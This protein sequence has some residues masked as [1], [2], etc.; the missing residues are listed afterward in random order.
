MKANLINE[1]FTSDYVANLLKARGVANVEDYFK[2]TR[3]YL[4]PPTNLKNIRLAAALYMRVVL[5][6]KPPYSRVLIVVDSDND[7]YTSAAIIYQY[8]KRLNCHCKVDYWLH[9]GKQHGLQDHIDR[10]M[11][12]DCQYDLIILPDSSSNDAHYHDMLDT[13]GI[14]CLILDHHLTDVKLS[15]NAVVVNNQLSPNYTNK[16]LTGAGVVYQFCRMI[17]SLTGQNWADDYM[18]LAAWGIIG[19]MGSMID[20]ENRYIVET[21]LSEPYI[22]NDFFKCL[23]DKRA[24]YI[25]GKKDPSWSE[26]VEKTNAISVAFYIVPLV[27]AMIRVGTMP[28]KERLFLAFIDG[29]AMVPCGKRGAKGTMERVDIESARE[30]VNAKSKQDKLKETIT[31]RLEA[32]IFKHDLLENKVLFVR[33]EDDD[34]FPSELNGLIAMQLSARF[35]K[36]T[37]IARLNDQGFDRGSARGLNQS[38]LKDFKQFLVDSGFFEYA[39]GHA[40]AFGVSIPDQRLREFHTYANEV[41]ADIDFGE[42]AYDVNFSRTSSAPDL[43]RLVME[44]GQAEPIWGQGNPQPL[45]H[46]TKMTVNPSNIRVMGANADTVKIEVNGIPYIK[47]HAKEFIEEL[48]Q[49]SEPFEMEI[50]GKPNL[51]EWMGRVSPQV[52]IEDYEIKNTSNI[53]F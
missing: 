41:L 27:N 36:P 8:T 30:C 29:G 9:E 40:N 33:L 4:Q 46:I 42:N 2:P 32:K 31:D 35:K 26:I 39:Q 23:L 21:G 16:E 19:D 18:D 53:N 7:G 25:T 14:P 20:M 3:D 49:H 10:L 47:F 15:D 51:N 50:V 24:Y 12:Q 5:N 43:S 6:D 44:L 13:I 45:I 38:E 34:V 37:I 1:N 48:Q 11:E 17:D 28:E 52:F 22:K